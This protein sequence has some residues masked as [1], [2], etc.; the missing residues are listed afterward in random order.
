MK[1][2]LTTAV[3][4][5]GQ[6][7]DIINVKNGYAK[8]FLLPEGLAMPFS[9]QIASQI[10]KMQADKDK[11][12]TE[13]MSNADKF[14]KEIAKITLNFTL[15]ASDKGILFGSVTPSMIASELLDGNKITLKP[16]DITLPENNI[17]ETGSHIAKIKL[18]D[19]ETDLKIIIKAEK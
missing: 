12:R 1:I 17:K 3:P 13:V 11:S 16:S 9:T 4:N 2:V 10:E 15:K 14:I 7:M 8:N 5:L 6:A 19:Q 18:G